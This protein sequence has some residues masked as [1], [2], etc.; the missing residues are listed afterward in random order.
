MI[1]KKYNLKH[2]Q[3]SCVTRIK[4]NIFSDIR[5]KGIKLIK[6]R[7]YYDNYSR[8][9]KLSNPKIKKHDNLDSLKTHSF[10]PDQII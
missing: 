1:F 2:K 6:L 9:I 4:N 7:L 10:K 5:Y 3:I 8:T